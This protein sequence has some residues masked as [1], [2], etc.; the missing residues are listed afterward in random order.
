PIFK[1][2]QQMGGAGKFIEPF[3]NI[4][5]NL[6]DRGVSSTPLVG[7]LNG[8]G[9]KSPDA[10]IARQVMGVTTAM[11]TRG[12][13]QTTGAGPS[14]PA[15]RS[16]WLKEGN[17]PYSVKLP[18]TD[19]W[20]PINKIPLLPLRGALTFDAALNDVKLNGGDGNAAAKFATSYGKALGSD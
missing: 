1:G 11:L 6:I 18:W 20:V 19:T 13:F 2:I 4:P 10:V 8:I 7:L 9:A 12:L 14:D 16:A 17:Q 5:A 3:A 15:M